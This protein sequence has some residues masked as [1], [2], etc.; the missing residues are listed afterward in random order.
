MVVCIFLMYV[1]IRNLRED[2][3]R[4]QTQVADILRVGQKTYSDYELKKIRIPMDS[5]II[6]AKLYDVD[7]NYICGISNEKKPY[8]KK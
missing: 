6:L 7:L 4:N 3:G 5:L 8:P 1:R 2:Q